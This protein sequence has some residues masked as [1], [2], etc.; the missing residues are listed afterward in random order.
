MQKSCQAMLRAGPLG[1][2]LVVA[3][4]G[5]ASGQSLV[6]PPVPP[7]GSIFL[8]P[9]DLSKH[10]L[11]PTGKACLSLYG[12]SKAQ[13]INPKIFEHWVSATNG[14]GQTIKLQV[15]Y[16]KTQDCI[17]MEVPPWGRKDAVLGIYPSLSD[18]RFEAKE[19]F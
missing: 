12:H 18:F 5:L 16:S 15:C 1:L 17:P 11:S 4:G 10:H 2:I 19:Q 6:T 7:Q 13:V 9:N 8:S 14:C 3:I